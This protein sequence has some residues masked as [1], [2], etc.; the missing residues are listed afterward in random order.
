MVLN[1]SPFSD[2]K[3]AYKTCIKIKTP[4]SLAVQVDGLDVEVLGVE[5]GPFQLFLIANGQRAVRINGKH[6]HAT[7]T[8]SH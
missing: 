2:K 6:L 4:T 1:G 7:A 3:S 5:E 8:H